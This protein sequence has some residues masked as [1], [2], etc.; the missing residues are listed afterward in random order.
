MIVARTRRPWRSMAASSFSSCGQPRARREP[1]TAGYEERQHITTPS[2]APRAIS[3]LRAAGYA[4]MTSE[5]G[6]GPSTPASRSSGYGRRRCASHRAAARRRRAGARR[7]G[8]RR[9]ADQPATSSNGSCQTGTPSPQT[10][11]TPVGVHAR[12]WTRSSGSR[13]SS[14][15]TV[16]DR[17][18]WVS[19]SRPGDLAAA[20]SSANAS[21]LARIAHHLDEVD[22][23][24]ATL[25][26]CSVRALGPRYTRAT[27][28]SSPVVNGSGNERICAGIRRSARATGVN[29][30]WG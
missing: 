13:R 11:C 7:S 1:S 18:D 2:S 6:G 5:W 28:S 30:G 19:T 17:R 9:G 24:C 16:R 26:T 23:D 3:D 10:C 14:S 20:I 22:H 21:A 8:E 29:A 12:S 27:A 25:S 15:A 4:R